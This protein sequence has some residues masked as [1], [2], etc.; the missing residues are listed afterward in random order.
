[1]NL[2]TFIQSLNLIYNMKKVKELRMA[3]KQ[4]QLSKI[5]Q[6]LRKLLQK[7]TES[8]QWLRFSF[9]LKNYI[10]QIQVMKSLVSK[11][12]QSIQKFLKEVKKIIKESVSTCSCIT[13]LQE[14]IEIQLLKLSAIIKM[15]MSILIIKFLIMFIVTY[16]K[17]HPNASLTAR[18]VFA[19]INL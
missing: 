7:A 19:L 5:G 14:L 18:I 17:I 12:I 11:C 3:R 16:I 9:L 6:C 8:L 4:A 15:K 13:L 2:E 10:N 1:M